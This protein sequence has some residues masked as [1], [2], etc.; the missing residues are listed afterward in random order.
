[1]TT[2]YVNGKKTPKE[3]LKHIEIH[4][5]GIK[6]MLEEVLYRRERKKAVGD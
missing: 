4:N 3:E 1:M 5:E 2:I 6:K